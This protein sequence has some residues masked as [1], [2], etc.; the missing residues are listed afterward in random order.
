MEIYHV[1]KLFIYL[2][3][4]LLFYLHSFTIAFTFIVQIY[5]EVYCSLLFSIAD[6]MVSMSSKSRAEFSN[7][8]FTL[9]PSRR[10]H[11]RRCSNYLRPLPSSASASALAS[12]R[13]ST[14]HPP[15]RN[16]FRLPSTSLNL[17]LSSIRY[18]VSQKKSHRLGFL[19]FSLCNPGPWV[20]FI[21]I[22]PFSMKK[23]RREFTIYPRVHII[24]Q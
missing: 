21:I 18:C 4:P 11:R 3:L 7:L 24:F 23:K 10:N 19:S 15:L 14:N 8:C 20:S 6:L 9:S 1:S 5:D 13:C 17:D 16:S 12:S 22:A 2:Q